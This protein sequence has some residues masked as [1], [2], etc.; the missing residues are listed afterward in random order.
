MSHESISSEKTLPADLEAERA[1]LGAILLNPPAL[2]EAC[3]IIGVEHLFLDAHRHVLQ[4]SVEL[5]QAEVGID[6][7]TVK[8]Q[9]QKAEKLEACGGAA[10]LVSLTDG[11]PRAINVRHYAQIVKENANLRKLIHLGNEAMTRAYQAEDSSKEILEG[12][13]LELLKLSES[14]KSQGGWL[15]IADLVGEAFKDIEELTHRKTDVSGLDTGF[16]DLNRLTQGFHPGNLIVIAGRPGHG[17]TSIG[18]NIIANAILKHQK[19]VGLFTI[20]MSAREITKRIMFADA[21]VDSHKAGSGY[22][23]KDDWK[24]ICASSGRLADTNLSLDEAGTLNIQELRSRSQQLAVSG[25]LDLIVIDY[26]QLMSGMG[27]GRH[28]NRVQEISDISRGLKS[29][30]KDLNIPIIAMSQLNREVEK[31]AKRRPRLADLRESGSIEQ[32]ADVVLFIW[33]EEL[34]E[35]KEENIGQAELIIGKQRNGPVGETVNLQFIKH[36]TKFV[37]AANTERVEEDKQFAW[38]NKE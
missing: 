34:R 33:R 37:S 3:E 24:R 4:A 16:P 38:Y 20:E 17:K 25:G 31:E 36:F 30:A 9:L 5:Q 32:D 2:F 26:L 23:S 27:S 13:Q 21:E 18:L 28:S 6:L 10:Y 12:L 14:G 35:R 11:I 22:I 7:I 8:N 15:K 29:L 1:V 19:K